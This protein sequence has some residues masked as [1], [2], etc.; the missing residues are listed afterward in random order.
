VKASSG[1]AEGEALDEPAMIDQ[2]Q[3]EGSIFRIGHGFRL[4]NAAIYI[5]S[6]GLQRGS[7]VIVAPL[8]L[9]RLSVSEYG[10][11]GLLLC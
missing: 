10:I 3:P 8:L 4:K 5:I 9:A 1:Q 7:T 6:N 2:A 11:Y